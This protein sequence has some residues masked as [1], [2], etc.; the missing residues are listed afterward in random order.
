MTLSLTTLQPKTN[1]FSNDSFNL[2]MVFHKTKHYADI[3]RNRL[4]LRNG[5]FCFSNVLKNIH[6]LREK[7][8]D[9]ESPPSV[10]FSYSPP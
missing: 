1:K 4:F 8:S 3:L 5:N 6:F 9:G 7:V 2:I 10:H